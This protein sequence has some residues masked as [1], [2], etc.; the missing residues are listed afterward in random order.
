MKHCCHCGLGEKI[1]QFKA[2]KLGLFGGILIVL[3][4]LFHVAECL[5]I[6]ALIVA[7][8]GE[9]VAT[10][11]ITENDTVETPSLPYLS[12]EQNALLRE[13]FYQSLV[14]YSP[15]TRVPIRIETLPD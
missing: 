4:L 11:E 6:P 7:F 15:L 5:V 14:K 10:S 1:H 12:Y 8:R 13:D 9:T 2:G 3:H